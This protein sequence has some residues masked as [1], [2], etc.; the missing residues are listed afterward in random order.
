MPEASTDKLVEH[1]S[2]VDYPKGYHILEA[3]K[4]ET[5]IFFIG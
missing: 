1:L 4:T 5:N 3:G 2:R